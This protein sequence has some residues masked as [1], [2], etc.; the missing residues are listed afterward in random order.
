MSRRKLMILLFGMAVL[1]KPVTTE[2][3]EGDP[4][5]FWSM[6]D[7]SEDE[8]GSGADVGWFGNGY[9]GDEGDSG[10]AWFERQ[11]ADNNSQTSETDF[12]MYR[13]LTGGGNSEP[14]SDH[15]DN[16]WTYGSVHPE[17]NGSREESFL[18]S[19]GHSRPVA[20]PSLNPGASDAQAQDDLPPDIPDE[21]RARIPK[22]R[23]QSANAEAVEAAVASA[24]PA[25]VNAG[26]A[27]QGLSQT[28]ANTAVAENAG[29]NNSEVF[30]LSRENTDSG[31]QGALAANADA[32]PNAALLSTGAGPDSNT[33]GDATGDAGGYVAES[34][35][36][37]DSYLEAPNTVYSNDFALIAAN[38]ANKAY[39][40]NG[41][42]VV[43]YLKSFGFAEDNIKTYN[44]DGS[45]AYT[46][47]TK[48]YEGHDSDGN[49][50]ILVMDA[51]GSQTTKELLGDATTSASYDHLGYKVYGVVETFYNE[52]KKNVS[53][54][55]DETK[56]YKIFATGH[57]LGGAVANLFA[58]EM[59]QD[60]KNDV[61]CYTFGAIDSIATKE[62]VEE[63]YE[64]IHNI[65]NDFD[66]FS[67]SQYGSILVNGAGS[68]FGKF[69]HIDEY[70]YDHRTDEQKS[71]W[72]M[73]Q[74]YNHVNHDMGNYV[75]D[76]MSGRVDCFEAAGGDDGNPDKTSGGTTPGRKGRGTQPV[77]STGGNRSDASPV[78]VNPSN[79]TSDTTDEV[80]SNE[81][82]NDAKDEV[83]S[84]ESAKDTKGEVISNKSSNDAKDE[85]ISNE[86]SNDAKDEVVS[87]ESAK[88]T[89]GEVISNK[90]SND[91]KGEA[92]SNK[93]SNDTKDDAISNKSSND[94][95]D[96][97]I[98]NES[99][100]DTQVGSAQDEMEENMIQGAVSDSKEDFG[101][102]AEQYAASA[103]AKILYSSGNDKKFGNYIKV[104]S[105]ITLREADGSTYVTIDVYNTYD[106][107]IRIGIDGMNRNNAA[108]SAGPW[109]SEEIAAGQHIV[110]TVSLDK[111]G[112][113]PGDVTIPLNIYK[114]DKTKL[115]STSPVTVSKAE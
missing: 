8:D 41:S 35:G 100:N 75:S 45:Y 68:E 55:I 2:A 104:T 62:P 101:A 76:V 106:A 114:A 58:A 65:Y 59:M 3:Y 18:H 66:T 1:T 5:Q 72:A 12:E 43:S 9:S 82:E 13:M 96:K 21:V 90:S 56:N 40:E 51:R 97:V 103:G 99:A 37:L 91:A 87:N 49:T 42:E 6:N 93:S 20:V 25:A 95:K 113:E 32:G 108:V 70:S 53:D 50:D 112:T 7:N 85:V 88:D 80:T 63:G 69:G 22:G 98:S 102:F 38:F 83:V 54:F 105:V 73:T 86:S 61:Y 48:P 10:W 39:S 77:P 84:N 29:Q 52:I 111:F 33:G 11:G 107:P 14:G 16:M 110:I 94:T 71:Q 15:N 79:D 28:E 109:M 81:P 19:T 24:A 78:Y 46:L 30:R 27:D 47:A 17:E 4:F 64:N 57:S 23:S 67:P 74:I 34:K 36:V 26:Q 31:E 60:P 92:I 89:K 44:Y 115:M